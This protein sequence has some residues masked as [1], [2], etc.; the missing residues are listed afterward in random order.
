MLAVQTSYLSVRVPATTLRKR[1]RA[2]RPLTDGSFVAP[3]I[4]CWDHVVERDRVDP[5]IPR[6]G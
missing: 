2:L 3:G 5:M 6:V 4:L 1:T